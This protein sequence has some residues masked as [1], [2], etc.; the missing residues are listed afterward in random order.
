M[1]NSV[2]TFFEETILN[3]IDLESYELEDTQGIYEK[4]QLVYNIFLEEKG[5]E[6]DRVGK[7][8]AF[9]DWLRGLPT[10]LTVPFYNSEIIEN[11]LLSGIDVSTEDK[12]YGFLES[13]WTKL[14]K[15][16]FTLKEN[17]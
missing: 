15:A 11:A 1:K 8:K 7:K 17:L 6:V 9:E 2:Y 5:W 10:V 3:S 4:V 13:Y 14:A 12:E 16:F